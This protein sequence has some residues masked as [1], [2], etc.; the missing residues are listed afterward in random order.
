MRPIYF[1]CSTAMAR[2]LTP[3]L[4]ARCPALE[5][6]MDDPNRDVLLAR[7]ADREIVVLGKTVLGAAEL[8]RLPRLRHIVFLGTGASS[9]VDL[10]AAAAQGIT[11]HV[12]PGYGSRAVAEHAL[13]LM[14]ACARQIVPMDRAIRAGGFPSLHGMEL[15]GKTLGL[16]GLGDIGAEVARLGAALGMD[17]VAW[18]RGGDA[19]GA[20][21]RLLPLD[22]VFACAHI[23]SLHV[24][25]TPET[26][27]LVDAR[28]LSLMRAG[29]LLIN[30]ARGAVVDE[31]ALVS[32]LERGTPAAAGLDVFVDEPP[33][34]DHPLRRL[35]NVVL[36][37]HAAFRTPEASRRLVER[38][39]AIVNDLL[40]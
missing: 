3:E 24:A 26:R 2:T 34:P 4:L 16:V 27:G 37:G 36:T 1:D 14:L 35:D 10:T 22:E 12:V 30:T 28:R 13:A 31:A 39:F 23:V 11:V 19:R 17:V 15:A 6:A 5:V 18:T 33:A 29:S 7:I 20:P 32:A 9:Y 38:V 8:A 21:A 25:L 40:R